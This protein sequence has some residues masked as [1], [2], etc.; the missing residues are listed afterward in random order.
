VSQNNAVTFTLDVYHNHNGH[1]A[2]TIVE[3]SKIFTILSNHTLSKTIIIQLINY[4][5]TLNNFPD[6]HL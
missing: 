5:K 2:P 3:R 1:R 4:L 6:Q